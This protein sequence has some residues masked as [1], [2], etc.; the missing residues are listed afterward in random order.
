MVLAVHRREVH[1]MMSRQESV[2]HWNMLADIEL[3][4]AEDL[5]AR[6]LFTGCQLAR[7]EM[8]QRTAKSIELEIKTGKPHCT[9]CLGPHE[10]QY[11]PQRPGARR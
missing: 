3:R 5:K 2:D 7:A 10:N 4:E 1:I 8:Y 6:G 9:V 11:C